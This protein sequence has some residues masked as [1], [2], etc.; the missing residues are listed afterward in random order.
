MMMAIHSRR[1]DMEAA[2]EVLA[3]QLHKAADGVQGTAAVC[4]GAKPY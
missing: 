2:E 3:R 4:T 1:G